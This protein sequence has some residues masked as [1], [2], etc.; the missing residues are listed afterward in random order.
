MFFASMLSAVFLLQSAAD[1]GLF[2]YLRCNAGSYQ[3]SSLEVDHLFAPRRRTSHVMAQGTVDGEHVKVVL[4]SL[5]SRTHHLT[6][7]ERAASLKAA[8]RSVPIYKRKDGGGS[9]SL[10]QG[11]SLDYVE[12]DF[13]EHGS[14]RSAIVFGVTLILTPL[15]FFLTRRLLLSSKTDPRGGGASVH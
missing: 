3:K 15:L 6:P 5:Y 13:F 11:R 4:K 12:A 10:I 7:R 1:V 9:E 14:R 8:G 2:A